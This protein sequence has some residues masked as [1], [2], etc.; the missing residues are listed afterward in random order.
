[1]PVGKARAATAGDAD[2]QFRIVVPCLT[3]IDEA[4]IKAHLRRDQFFW[5]DLTDPAPEEIAALGRLFGFHPLALEDTEHFGQ[6]PKLDNYGD[7]IFL[8]FYGAWRHPEDDPE[9]LREVH[10]F[11]AG[12]YLVTVH[13]DPLPPLDQQR[14]QLDGRV[15]HS[16]QFL[17]YRV[18]DALTDSFFPWL[19]DM[20]EQIDGLEQS[21]LESPDEHQLEQLFGL[22]RQ[23]VAVRKVVTPQRDLF[24][25]SVDQIAE[26]PGLELDERDYFRDVY[27]HLIRISDLIDSYRDLLSGATDL[28]LSTLSN[29][30]NEVMKQLTVIATIF[31]PL[32][33]IT[34]FFGQNFGF[35]INHLIAGTWTFFVVGIG[36]MVA[37]CIGLLAFFRRKGWV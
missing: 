13:R 3:A 23:L 34:G 36:S 32:A 17:L 1:M 6:R 14:A 33:F 2:G 28:Y 18:L 16:E 15:L 21:V 24:A 10:L 20:D 22:R 26:L 9:P 31:L 4:S 35:M 30:Q 7:H 8:V 27:D 11:L 12:R 25:R 37:T 29:R 19:S 5:L